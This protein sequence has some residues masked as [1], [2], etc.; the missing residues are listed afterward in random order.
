MSRSLMK[1]AGSP[2]WAQSSWTRTTPTQKPSRALN[3]S[4]QKQSEIVFVDKLG[5]ALREYTRSYFTYVTWITTTVRQ[6]LH[7][8]FKGC[9]FISDPGNVLPI[10]QLRPI[11]ELQPWM[12]SW[13]VVVQHLFTRVSSSRR[14][15]IMDD[16]RR[17]LAVVTIYT[18][19]CVRQ[20]SV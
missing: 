7:S 11:E 20:Q 9:R 5:T 4:F 18:F 1:M 3:K 2:L 15:W 14:R 8:V 13:M 16:T 10:A 12:F 17:T 6:V 19:S